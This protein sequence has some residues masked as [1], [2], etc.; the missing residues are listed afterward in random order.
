[1]LV[2]RVRMVVIND[3]T[4]EFV[5]VDQIVGVSIDNGKSG[6]SWITTTGTQASS[7]E[8]PVSLRIKSPL[9]PQELLARMRGD[10]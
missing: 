6:G 8:V 9:S 3:E 5:S 10:K 1:M 4:Q 7:H 2:R